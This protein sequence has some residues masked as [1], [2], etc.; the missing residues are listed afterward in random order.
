M[1]L[2]SKG[3]GFDKQK[4]LP[5]THAQST[6]NWNQNKIIDKIYQFS[7]ASKIY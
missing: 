1:M 4:K 5:E 7:E 3:Q 2:D 6:G